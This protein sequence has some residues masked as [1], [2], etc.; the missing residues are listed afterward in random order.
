M[1]SAIEYEVVSDAHVVQIAEKICEYE[2]LAQHLGF[3]EPDVIA[4]RKNNKSYEE[5]KTSFLLIWKRRLADE[6]TYHCLMEA[7]KKV[8]S[9]R[10]LASYIPELLG[11]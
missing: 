6:A 9:E 3:D 10:L 4:I 2:N 7:A 8:K 5:E 1:A 11:N